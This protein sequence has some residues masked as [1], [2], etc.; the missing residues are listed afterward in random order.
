MVGIENLLREEIRLAGKFAWQLRAVCGIDQFRAEGLGDGFQIGGGGGFI[1]R[2]ADMVV[3][4]VAEVDVCIDGGLA[5]R[6]GFAGGFYHDRVEEGA[7]LDVES[8]LDE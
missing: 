7:A 6:D 3:V 2:N 4:D 5:N 8:G 1:E